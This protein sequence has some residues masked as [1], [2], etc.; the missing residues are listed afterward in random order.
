MELRTCE[1]CEKAFEY[2]PR[3][4]V[5]FCS[6]PCRDKAFAQNGPVLRGTD[7]AMWK[8]GRK[9]D[10][11]GYSQVRVGTHYVREH[12]MICGRILG[13]PLGK[14]IVIHHVDNGDRAN[15]IGANLVIC[16]NH[17]YHMLLHWRTK[18][19]AMGGDPNKDHYC[20][21]CHQI[22]PRQS[23][24][25]Y[26]KSVVGLRIQ[27]RACHAQDTRNSRLRKRRHP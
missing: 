13:K 3:K 18:I 2:H 21:I 8:G 5:R 25:R 26:S 27:C 23:F 24:G 7:N 19:R 6:W 12:R 14:K 15:N 17:A 9:I 16:E 10:K 22:L 4:R 1:W 11:D 20:S